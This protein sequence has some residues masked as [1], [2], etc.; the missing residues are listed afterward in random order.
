MLRILMKNMAINVKRRIVLAAMKMSANF[1]KASLLIG[2]TQIIAKLL[3]ADTSPDQ[4][5]RAIEQ[6]NVLQ[7]RSINTAQ[8]YASLIKARLLPMGRALWEIVANADRPGATQ[9]TLAA[10]L[11]YSPLIAEFM[12]T[13]LSDEYRRMSP[14]LEDR[15]WRS[16]Y[17]DMTLQHSNLGAVSESG[18][19]KLRLNAFR[20]LKEAGYLGS[21]SSRPLLQV[22]ILPEVKSYLVQHKHHDILQAMECAQ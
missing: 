16:F 3:L 20:I 4:F 1:T 2:E 22:R 10:T 21:G 14:V 12:R 15:V 19:H 6:D 9:A 8:S 5:K 17:A 7:V 11:H 18:Q 13:A